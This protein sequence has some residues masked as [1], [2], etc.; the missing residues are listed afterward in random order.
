VQGNHNVQVIRVSFENES[1][2]SLAVSQSDAVYH[3]AA[4]VGVQLVADEPVRTTQTT[5]HL[6]GENLDSRV[7]EVRS[8]E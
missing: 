4:A 3:L 6:W 8:L 7:A 5:I 1:V 2:A